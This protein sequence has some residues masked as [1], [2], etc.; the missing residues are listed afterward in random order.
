MKANLL[1]KLKKYDEELFWLLKIYLIFFYSY[2][3]LI[4][5]DANEICNYIKKSKIFER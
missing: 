3:K 1:C 4:E 5:L 2:N